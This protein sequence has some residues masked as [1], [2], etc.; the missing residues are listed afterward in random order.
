METPM[1]FGLTFDDILLLPGYADFSRADISLTTQLTKSISLKIPFVSAPMDTVTEVE[2]AAKLAELGGIGIIHRNLSVNDQANQV[3]K[4]AQRKL[5]TGAAVGGSEG[6]KERVEALVKAG[7]NVI[8]V[9]SAHGFAKPIIDA[10][11]FIKQTYPHIAVMAGNI[12]TYDGA[13]AL[14][15]AICG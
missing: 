4:V 15:E 9:D 6:F 1:S 2:M 14:I 8:C 5:L 11:R 10:T 12:A 13:K 7:V 3:A